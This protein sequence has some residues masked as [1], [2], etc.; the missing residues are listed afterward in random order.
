MKTDRDTFELL[1][2]I[3]QSSPSLG[4]LADRLSEKLCPDHRL[5]ELNVGGVSDSPSSTPVALIQP[6]HQT[7]SKVNN[8]VSKYHTRTPPRQKRKRR[9]TGNRNPVSEGAHEVPKLETAQDLCTDE[10]SGFLDESSEAV[11]AESLLCNDSEKVDDDEF[12]VEDTNH[13]SNVSFNASVDANSDYKPFSTEV[14]V[15]PQSSPTNELSTRPSI[16]GQEILHNA[17]TQQVVTGS[18]IQPTAE[19]WAAKASFFINQGATKEVNMANEIEQMKKRIAFLEG[20]VDAK[21]DENQKVE[22]MEEHIQEQEM[23][24]KDCKEKLATKE[25]ELN[26]LQEKR[27]TEVKAAEEKLQKERAEH[28]IKIE[29]VEEEMK[30]LQNQLEEKS[31]DAERLRHKYDDL[32]KSSTA[33]IK[34][35]EEKLK[36]KEEEATKLKEEYSELEKKDKKKSVNWI[37]ITKRQ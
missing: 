37:N 29:Q 16:I 28:K 35:L 34:E 19:G 1:L 7:S 9:S 3:L 2:R 31:V 18:G 33:K 32:K 25:R 6:G 36:A 20:I 27:K 4:H 15:K 21:E 17:A 5:A 23:E 22:K 11:N 10:E 12:C 30:L 8:G 14:E 13:G 24:L 26:L